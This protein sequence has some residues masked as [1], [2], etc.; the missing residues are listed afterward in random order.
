MVDVMRRLVEHR[1]P[2]LVVAGVTRHPEVPHAPTT[3]GSFTGCHADTGFPPDLRHARPQPMT[4]RA[5]LRLVIEHGYGHEDDH[6]QPDSFQSCPGGS[7][8]GNRINQVNKDTRL[9]YSTSNRNAG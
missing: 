3:L 8:S 2:E 5:T 9:S 7:R 4:E 1:V 6:A